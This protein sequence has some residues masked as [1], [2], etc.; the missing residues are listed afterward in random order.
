M[1]KK[2]LLVGDAAADTGF[3]KVLHSLAYRWANNWDLYILGVNY[4]GD[5]HPI[6][7]VAKLFN[8][9]LR[10]FNDVYGL[11]RIPELTTKIKPDLV[12][13]L[14]DPWI[15]SQYAKEIPKA[16]PTK[17][18]FYT[19]VDAVNVKS[20]FVEPLHAFTQGVV[21]TYFGGS[22]L[23]Q[24]GYSK[25]LAI[26]PHGIDLQE[27]FPMDKKAV[28]AEIKNKSL[29]DNVDPED[30]IVQVVDR[31][32]QRK[33]I[34]LAMYGFALWSSNKPK[35]VKLWYHGALLDVGYDIAQL[36]E[37]FGITDRMIYTVK[38]LDPAHG[39]STS[40]LNAVYNAADVRVS[41]SGGEGWGLCT[42]ESMATRTANM[43]VNTAALSEWA[44]GGV[45]YIEPSDIPYV[46]TNGLNTIHAQASIQSYI[47]GLE[48]MYTDS[49]YREYI[50]ESGYAL[51]T[52]SN[53][54]W[55]TVAAQF[56]AVFHNIIDNG[57]TDSVTD[58]VTDL[59]NDPVT[60]PVIDSVITKE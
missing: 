35:N 40:V 51:V 43:V 11:T 42:M 3:A 47:D 60:D 44:R 38:N 25:N 1:K 50:A 46:T 8:P 26:I 2:L 10:D 13:Y 20:T 17:H 45:H 32:S 55:D 28:R 4:D 33:R 18:V 49:L 7:Q 16:Y 23:Q 21:Y 48:K 52:Q 27:F 57:A 53:F 59:V 22:V 5:Y 37:F 6:S 9:R 24:S 36:A 58:P 54:L 30:F 12:F 14:N 29:T 56:N 34:D 15:L 41:T 19:P 31:N 39:V